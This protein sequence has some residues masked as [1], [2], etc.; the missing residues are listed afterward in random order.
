MGLVRSDATIFLEDEMGEK[1]SRHWRTEKC[2]QHFG[3][4]FWREEATRKN[5]S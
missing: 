5:V 2:I 3:R 4:K 1:C